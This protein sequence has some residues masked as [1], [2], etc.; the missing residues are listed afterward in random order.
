MDVEKELQPKIIAITGHVEDEY[1]EKAIKSGMDKIIRKPL[2]IKEFGQLMVET[3]YISKVPE[4][5]NKW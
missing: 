2:L 3:N 5:L 1:M 4:H